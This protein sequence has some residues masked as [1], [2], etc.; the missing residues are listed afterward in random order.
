MT[1]FM[2]GL[3][4]VAWAGPARYGSVRASAP[5]A[6]RRRRGRGS[7]RRRARSPPGAGAVAV[8]VACAAQDLD[9]AQLCDSARD[10]GLG[11]GEAALPE[12]ADQLVLV[13]D[14]CA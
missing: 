3:L 6:P 10:G 5:G 7:G 1:F 13:R 8:A 9:Q 11:D 4:G 14:G 12:P 2:L